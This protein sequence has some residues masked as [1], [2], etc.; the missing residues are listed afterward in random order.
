MLP[1]DSDLRIVEVHGKET[2]N[3]PKRYMGMKA[4]T[5]GLGGPHA[6]FYKRNLGKLPDP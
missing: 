1:A 4:R 5:D 6:G 3:N 2:H